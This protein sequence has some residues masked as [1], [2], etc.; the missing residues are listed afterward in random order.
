MEGGDNMLAALGEGPA[1][2]SATDVAASQRR[3]MLA[4]MVSAVAEKGYVATAVADVTKRARVSRATFYEQFEDKGDCFVAA[5]QACVDQLMGTIGEKVGPEPAPRQALRRLL[6]SYLA[7]L[8][9]FPE[10]ARVCL[11]E[12]YAAGPRAAAH[13]RQAQ[14]E[15]GRLLRAIHTRLAEAGDP[16]RDL[17]DLD[18]E[19]LVGGI[20][21]LATNRVAQGE[22]ETL[23]ELLD[24]IEAFVLVNFGL[25]PRA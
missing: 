11:V 6:E 7:G 24:A 2:L 14:L 5:V 19:L 13:R 20:A 21:S 16:V 10:G 15:F 18:I 17:D 8:A 12:M 22:T 4:A 1:R 23:P 25:R 3:R 9:A